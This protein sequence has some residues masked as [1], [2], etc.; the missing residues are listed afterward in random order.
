MTEQRKVNTAMVV[1]TIIGSALLGYHA[2]SFVLGLGI[3]FLAMAIR[4]W[5]KS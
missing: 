2:N 1:F 4:P 5:R 3:F